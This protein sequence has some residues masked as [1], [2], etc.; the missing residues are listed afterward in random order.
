MAWLEI[1]MKKPRK[2]MVQALFF[3]SYAPLDGARRSGYHNIPL[4]LSRR[5]KRSHMETLVIIFLHHLSIPDGIDRVG[6]DGPTPHL[7][8][9]GVGGGCTTTLL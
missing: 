7:T 1:E 4:M 3:G 6:L 9:V 5:S 2:K 8:Q